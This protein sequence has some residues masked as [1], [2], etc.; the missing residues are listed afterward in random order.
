MG[1]FFLPTTLGEEIES[2]QN[3]F[4]CC[5][6][7]NGGRCINWMSWDKLTTSKTHGGLN[8]RDIEGVNL[9]MLGKQSWKLTTNAHS[10]LTRVLKSKYFSKKGF[11]ESNLNHNPSYILRIIWS[12][13]P[14][15]TLGYR[16]KISHNP[17]GPT[18]TSLQW[19]EK[20]LLSANLGP[21]FS[22]AFV[23]RQ[24]NRVAYTLARSSILHISPH[25]FLRLL[26]VSKH[27]D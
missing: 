3:R 10:L 23:R 19:K 6:N 2:I 26:I 21:N 25:N 12:T 8:F 9:G 14:L 7:R 15:L 11:L 13:I 27:K 22:V 5:S 1:A 24:V 4:Y 16:W 18:F 20:L 17:L